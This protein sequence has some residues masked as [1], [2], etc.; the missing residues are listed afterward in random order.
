M[1]ESDQLIGDLGVFRRQA[2]LIAILPPRNSSGICA[3][4]NGARRNGISA[5]IDHIGHDLII[6]ARDEGRLKGM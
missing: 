5:F 3:S 1:H 4:I 2:W 6:N